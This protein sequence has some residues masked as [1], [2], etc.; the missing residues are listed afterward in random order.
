MSSRSTSEFLPY[1]TGADFRLAGGCG[2]VDAL[3]EADERHAER[4]Q[5]VS[6]NDQVSEIAPSHS[7]TYDVGG[8][9]EGGVAAD[10]TVLGGVTE[11]AAEGELARRLLRNRD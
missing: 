9:A 4:L 7:H 5:L 8:G 2:G 10:E 1:P 6:Q 3:G 11:G